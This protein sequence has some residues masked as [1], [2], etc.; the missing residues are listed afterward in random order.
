M[1]FGLILIAVAS[2]FTSG[3][4]TILNDDLQPVNV[5]TANNRDVEGDISGVPFK[6]P[7]VVHVPRAKA[8]KI[9]TVSNAACNKTTLL[10]SSVD[11]KF[12]I[13]ILTGGTFGSTTDYAS[14]KMW[15]Y[16]DTVVIQCN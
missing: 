7:G 16:Q 14:E 2:V 5:A 6:G 1:K 10:A 4:A 13:N 3:C 9:I 15:K 11:P 8:D 12:F